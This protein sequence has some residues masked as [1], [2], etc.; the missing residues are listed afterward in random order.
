VTR[1]YWVGDTRNTS[2][3]W[4]GHSDDPGQ[5]Q[6]FGL[7]HDNYG[8]GS[9]VVIGQ[10][11]GNNFDPGHGIFGPYG[12]PGP[13]TQFFGNNELGRSVGITDTFPDSSTGPS[14]TGSPNI[15][16]YCGGD[17]YTTKPDNFARH[18]CNG[19]TYVVGTSIDFGV[20]PAFAAGAG[21]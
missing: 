3:E 5:T 16:D 14:T 4:D 21:P 2:I 15:T 9:R 10:C 8:D 6:D 17:G 19:T 12:G 7:I 20:P 18:P 11:C 1:N 13:G